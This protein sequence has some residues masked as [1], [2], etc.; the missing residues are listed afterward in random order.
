MKREACA[1][2]TKLLLDINKRDGNGTGCK[3]KQQQQQH[4]QV[5]RWI[6]LTAR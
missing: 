6:V 1:G 4:H 3:H 5:K 2:K